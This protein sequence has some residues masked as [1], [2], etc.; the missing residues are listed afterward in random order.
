MADPLGPARDKRTPVVEL[1]LDGWGVSPAAEGNAI[2]AAKTPVMDGLIQQY[3]S[4]ALQAAGTAVGLP[5]GEAGSSE[6]GHLNLGAGRIVFQ[7]VPA[8]TTAIANGSF[9]QNQVFIDAV[10]HV[11]KNNSALHF[12]GVLSPEEGSKGLVHVTALLELAKQQKFDRVYLHLLLDKEGALENSMLNYLQEL[13]DLMKKAGVGTI[14]TISGEYYAMDREK[15][16]EHTARAYSLMVD[17][18]GPSAGSVDE[19]IGNSKRQSL[20]TEFIEPTLITGAPKIGNND[21]IIFFNWRPEQSQQLAK[22]FVAPYFGQ[23]EHGKPLKN[24]YLVSMSSF[25]SDDDVKAAFLADKIKD[26]LTETLSKQGLRQLHLAETEKFAYVTMYFNGGYEQ[27]FAG[28]QDVEVP[29]VQVR[30]YDEAPAMS[31]PQVTDKLIE[32]ITAGQADF[33]LANLANMDMVGHTGNFEAAV[34][35]AEV[36]DQA[37]G[38]IVEACQQQQIHLIITADHGNAERMTSPRTGIANVDHSNNPVPFILISPSGLGLTG[39]GRGITDGSL[40]SGMLADVAP[41]VLALLGLGKPEAM[42]GYSLLLTADDG[43]LT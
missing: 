8:I 13:Q 33:Y 15:R 37:V 18:I 43:S 32:S 7:E 24:L 6:V 19:V 1:I 20:P 3:P 23:F 40:P 9:F 17:G 29:S 35:A 25:A 41:T 16:W 4:M 36:V 10:E 42:T 11:K 14:A 38:R 34:K 12:I 39:Q 2:Q 22:A 31:T 21:S 26:G 27:P 28:E 5:W 30:S